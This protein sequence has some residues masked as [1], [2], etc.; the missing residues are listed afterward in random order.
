MPKKPTANHREYQAP[1]KSGDRLTVFA[2][3]PFFPGFLFSL[4]FFA[5]VAA[6]RAV[7]LFAPFDFA[8]PL[9]LPL[10]FRDECTSSSES[11]VS[12]SLRCFR[13][14]D[15]PSSLCSRSKHSA[16]FRSSDSRHVCVTGNV[17]L[18]LST[19]QT[20]DAT[21]NFVYAHNIPVFSGGM[22]R[23]GDLQFN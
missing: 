11:Y 14:V 5:A 18:S 10:G 6:R 19:A 16:A 1:P 23:K 2:G 22:H 12:T 21:E 20:N 4:T 17:H 15:R 13:R 7:I 9:P 3:S 8:G